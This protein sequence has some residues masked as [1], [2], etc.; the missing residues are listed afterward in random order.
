MNQN[1]DEQNACFQ[2][3]KNVDE[4]NEES[5]HCS[6]DKTNTCFCAS[7]TYQEG[8]GPLKSPKTNK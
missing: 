7:Q 4:A 2:W 5:D 3:L 6:P 1:D 8:H